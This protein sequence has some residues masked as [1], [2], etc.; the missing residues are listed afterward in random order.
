M[1]IFKNKSSNYPILNLPDPTLGVCNRASPSAF[2]NRHLM[3]KWL[4]E[5]RC[6]GTGGPFANSR[7]LWMDNTSGHYGSEVEDTARE[8]RTKL[9]YFPANATDKVQPADHFPIQRIKEHCRRLA[10]RRNMDAIRNGDWKTET[11]SSWK[12][13][14]PGKKFYLELAARCIRL[15][16]LEKDKNGDSWAK[17]SMIQCGLDVSRDGVWKVDQLSKELKQT[18]AFYPDAFEEGYSQRAMSANL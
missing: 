7:V 4:R 16:N 14:N 13:A 2:I 11:S 15:V 6:W 12:L 3:A 18:I 5:P 9:K 10:E 1:H 8:L 17:N